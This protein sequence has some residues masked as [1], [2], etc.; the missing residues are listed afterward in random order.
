MLGEF[1]HLGLELFNGII[2]VGTL[3]RLIAR[4]TPRFA[5]D[6]RRSDAEQETLCEEIRTVFDSPESRL[7]SQ[8]GSTG[9]N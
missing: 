6:E 2:H 4:R 8:R 1:T 3:L 7:V 5:G 9:V